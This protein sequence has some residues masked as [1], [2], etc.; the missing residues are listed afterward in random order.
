MPFRLVFTTDA[1]EQKNHLEATNQSKYKKV[2]KA[3]GQIEKDPH[4]PG[5]HTHKYKSLKAPQG[6]PIFQS[7][8]ENLTA[9]AYR[10]FWYYGPRD[11]DITIT[12]IVNHP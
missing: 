11:N 9:A 12:S 2:R 10:I 6:K 3:L 1:A 8:A 7:Y 5:L 4:Y